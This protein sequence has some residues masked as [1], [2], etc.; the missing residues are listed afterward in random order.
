MYFNT[1]TQKM[2][3]FLSVTIIQIYKTLDSNGKITIFKNRINLT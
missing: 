1:T 2:K 3:K